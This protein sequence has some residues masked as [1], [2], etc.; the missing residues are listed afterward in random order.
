MSTDHALLAVK[1][2]IGSR[3]REAR[4]SLGLK[5]IEL[6]KAGEVSRITQ[7]NYENDQT[8]PD[9]NY[10]RKIQTL[11]VD[12]SFVLFGLH[13][14]QLIS[15]SHQ[16]RIDWN[17]LDIALEEIDAFCVA[18]NETCPPRL[19]AKLV[20]QFYEILKTNNAVD[21]K[22]AQTLVREMWHHE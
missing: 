9:L 21:K 8:P 12:I 6:A 13:E 7:Y 5:Q 11:G 19:K 10:L 20:R 1:D 17:L 15:T 14:N 16:D 18:L 22:D 3:L 2:G 4:E